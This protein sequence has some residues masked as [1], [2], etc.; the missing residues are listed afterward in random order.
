MALQEAPDSSD[1]LLKCSLPH[2]IQYR[3]A[4]HTDRGVVE[5]Q[6]NRI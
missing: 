6:G 5:S 2:S 3:Y 4:L 1:L